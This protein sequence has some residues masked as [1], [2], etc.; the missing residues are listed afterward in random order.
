[1]ATW[2]KQ[3]NSKCT[4]GKQGM[5]TVMPNQPNRVLPYSSDSG[6]VTA[7]PIQG[8]DGEYIDFADLRAC[9]STVTFAEIVTALIS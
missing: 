9:L 8:L 6:V 2:A 7:R 5:Q 1:M 3:T 4:Y